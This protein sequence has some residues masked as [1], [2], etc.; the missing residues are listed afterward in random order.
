MKISVQFFSINLLI[1]V[2]FFALNVFSQTPQQVSL[3]GTFNVG[4]EGGVQFTSINQYSSFYVPSSKVGFTAGVF[5]EY[6]LSEAFKIKVAALYDSR[7]FELSGELIYA[8]TAMQ[9]YSNSYYLYQVDYAINYLTIPI[10]IGYEKGS[11]KF[12]IL[13]NINV[14]YSILLNANM[15]GR[16]LYYFDPGDGFDLTNTILQQGV[17]NFSLSG[18]TEGVAFSEILKDSQEKYRVEEFNTSDFGMN[19]MIGG[20]YQATPQLGFSVSFGFGFS[21]DQVFV[22]PEVNSKWSQITKINMGVIYSLAGR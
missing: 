19:L 9:S 14:Y 1:L 13:L 5:G 4:L 20:L 11:D 17:N 3:K 21:F 18:A 16:E 12:K 2:S 22:N 6:Y 15:N 8:D 10:G 7:P